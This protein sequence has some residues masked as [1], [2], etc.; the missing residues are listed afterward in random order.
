MYN[1]CYCYWSPIERSNARF[2][3]AYNWLYLMYYKSRVYEPN[4][5]TLDEINFETLAMSRGANF[6]RFKEEEK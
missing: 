1:H 6:T 5:N 3:Y 4:T 2:E